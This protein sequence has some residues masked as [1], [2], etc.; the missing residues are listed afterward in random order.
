MF[1]KHNFFLVPSAAI[2]NRTKSCHCEVKCS[3]RTKMDQYVNKHVFY[4]FSLV[5][6]NDFS[7]HCHV[8][9]SSAVQY[10]SVPMFVQEAP[11]EA[12]RGPLMNPSGF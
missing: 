5:N 10:E 11:F 2:Q 8:K 12:T 6:I 1:F 4:I 7:C 9:C 3:S